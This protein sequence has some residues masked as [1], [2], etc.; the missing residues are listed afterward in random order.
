MEAAPVCTPRAGKA[1]HEGDVFWFDSCGRATDRVEDCHGRACLGITCA[2]ART[3][4]DRCGTVT[5]YGRCDGEIARACVLGELVSIDCADRGERCAQGNEG[6]ECRAAGD[7]DC[8]ESAPDRCRGTRLSQCVDGRTRVIDCALRNAECVVKESVGQCVAQMGSPRSKVEICNGIDD[9]DDDA[10][11]E[12]AVCETVKLVPIVARGAVLTDLPER[13][14]IELAIVN[15]IYQ[16]RVFEWARPVDTRAPLTVFPKGETLAV[17][18]ELTAD[19]RT[20]L[21]P[22]FAIPVLFVEKLDMEPPKS[23]ISTLPNNRCGG[24][25][26]EDAPAPAYG[27]IVLAD[28]RMPETLAHELGHYLGLCHTHE[29]VEHYAATDGDAPFCELTG[30]GICD[31]PLD[32]GRERCLVDGSCGVLCP[33]DDALPEAANAMSYYLGCRRALSA[34]QLHEAERNLALRRGWS[35]CLEPDACACQPGAAG[36]CPAE[37]SCHPAGESHYTCGMDGPALPGAPCQGSSQCSAGALCLQLA[38]S[39]GERGRCV[40]PCQPG[41]AQCDC[42]ELGPPFSVCREDLSP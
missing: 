26:V 19:L 3:L 10:V 18:R 40:R 1:C 13:M 31:T 34:E 35:A 15:R 4:A 21:G 2:S 32:P 9:D 42:A 8:R 38:G 27:L 20:Q 29:Q 17:A 16:P 37:M 36:T 33:H 23:G 11:D 6:V 24:V 5:A 12:R 14:Q 39:A 22:A 41:A 7:D 28:S 25:R 30:D